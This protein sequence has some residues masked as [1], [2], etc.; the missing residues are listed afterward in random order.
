MKNS[1]WNE[2]IVFIH[3]ITPDPDPKAHTEN[4]QSLYRNIQKKLEQIRKQNKPA[5]TLDPIQVEWGWQSNL[6]PITNDEYL[7]KAELALSRQAFSLDTEGR[8]ADPTLNPFRLLRPTVRRLLFYGFADLMYYVSRD[9][10]IAVRN[11]VFRYIADQVCARGFMDSPAKLSLTFITHSAGTIIAHDLLYHL[12]RGPE[13]PS[14]VREVNEVLRELIY[15]HR[16]RI[17]R[18]Y[19]M[20]SPLTPLMFRS[21][22]LITKMRDRQVLLPQNLGFVPFNDLMGP[23][24]IN[25]WDKDDMAAYPVSFLYQNESHLIEDKYIDVSDL[26]TAA[27]NAYWRSPAVAQYIAK[28]I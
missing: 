16:L 1:E 13:H 6:H 27:H 2:I 14:E 10:E 9:G 11:H 7:A 8:N 21:D 23:R 22:S 5:F 12:F 4:Y 19:T 3:G 15:R 26:L 25:I 17:R 18:L 28:T 24:W 20:G